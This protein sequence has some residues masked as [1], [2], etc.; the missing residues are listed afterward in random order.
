ML[1]SKV[2]YVGII[3]IYVI[4]E[5]ILLAIFLSSLYQNTIA[6]KFITYL[7]IPFAGY[8]VINF[9]YNESSLNNYSLV[10]ESLFFIVFLIYFFYEKMKTVVHYPL[11]QSITFWICVSLLIYFA[12][13]FFF[14]LFINSNADKA[15]LSQKKIIYSFVT[16]SKN[17][18]FCLA[19]FASEDNESELERIE[20]FADV[21]LD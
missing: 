14:F 1:K 18:F 5:Y 7:T 4:V 2:L 12:G 3:R 15:F 19:L 8:S 11:Y 16:I 13:N 9:F 20:I 21:N 10:A 6:K 17:I